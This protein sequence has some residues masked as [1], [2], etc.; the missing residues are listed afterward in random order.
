MCACKALS[1][2]HLQT[3]SVLVSVFPGA[4]D[5]QTEAQNRVK[6]PVQSDSTLIKKQHGGKRPGA[7]RKPDVIKRMIGRLK[8]ATAMEVLS[9]VD[10]EKVIGEIFA[11]GSLTLK[12]RGH[13]C[14][15]V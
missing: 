1:T 4:A 6:K 12:Q 14:G 10:V 9:S 3:F 15:M 13:T 8:P 2:V 7:G 5:M 11:K